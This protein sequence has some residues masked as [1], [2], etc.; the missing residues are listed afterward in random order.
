MRNIQED[1]QN[2]KPSINPDS[3]NIALAGFMGT[4]KTTS[5]KVLAKRL[6]WDFI[7]IDALIEAKEKKSIPQIF[8]LYGELYFRNCETAIISEVAEKKRTIISL[9]GGAL[10]RKENV[11][12]LKKNTVIICLQAEPS[13]ILLRTMHTKDRPLLLKSKDALGIIRELMQERKESYQQAD[14]FLDTSSLSPEE[15]AGALQDILRHA[16]IYPTTS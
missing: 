5:G 11:D 2:N 3:M 8:Q 16:N 6:L 12:A 14:F 10:Q 13:I 4:G 15:T 1:G 7:D 9:G